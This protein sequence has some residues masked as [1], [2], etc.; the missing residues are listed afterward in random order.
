MGFFDWTQKKLRKN[1]NHSRSKSPS[2]SMTLDDSSN[3]NRP[4]NLTGSVDI[5]TYGVPFVMNQTHAQE[6]V[7]RSLPFPLGAQIKEIIAGGTFFVVRSDSDE[8]FFKSTSA[9][10]AKQLMSYLSE[11]NPTN[12]S[13]MHGVL[14]YCQIDYKKKIV[15]LKLKDSSNTCYVLSEVYCG[16]YF[17]ILRMMNDLL[18]Y[19]SVT[20]FTTL[21]DESYVTSGRKELKQIYVGPLS[22]HMI[23]LKTDNTFDYF[24]CYQRFNKTTDKHLVSIPRGHVIVNC[25]CAGRTTFIVVEDPSNHSHHLYVHGDNQF[26]VQ[27]GFNSTA[28]FAELT[29][30]PFV[31]KRVKDIKCGYFHTCILLEDGSVY[32]CGYNAYHQLGYS[33]GDSE[34]KQVQFPNMPL[35]EDSYSHSV[36]DEANSFQTKQVLC[37]SIATLFI[38]DTGFLMVGD[39]ISS[40]RRKGLFASGVQAFH[41]LFGEDS[42]ELIPGSKPLHSNSVAVGGWHFVVYNKTSVSTKYLKYFFNNLERFSKMVAHS[43][44]S[45]KVTSQF[46]DISLLF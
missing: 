5:V 15:D 17:V 8:L 25:A 10:D 19:L 3:H 43:E 45:E 37:S 16:Q 46:S 39:P 18:V 1:Q 2:E 41:Y 24:E 7:R 23:A 12:P 31:G 40:L 13:S 27:S 20:N 21:V 11:T 26:M 4:M 42:I 28:S 29:N 9:S 30:T 6:F 38:N 32:T 22:Q 44:T 14:N 35:Q 34:L 33:G 36:H